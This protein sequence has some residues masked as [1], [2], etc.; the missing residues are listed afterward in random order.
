MGNF[1]DGLDAAVGS[2]GGG[3]WGFWFF[4]GN[5]SLRTDKH[6][7]TVDRPKALLTAPK[8][9]PALKDTIFADGP[10]DAS[11]YSGGNNYWLFRG[12]QALRTD[13]YTIN[14]EMKDITADSHWPAL[15]GTV[16][17]DGV[18]AAVESG[19]GGKDGFWFFKGDKTARTDKHGAVLDEGVGDITGPDLWP[20]LKDTIFAKGPIE[21]AL[22]SGGG[23]YWLF[24]G[25]Q[26]VKTNGNEIRGRISDIAAKPNW[27]ALSDQ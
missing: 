13:G 16:F 5:Q 18:D 2:E 9:W 7:A 26:T 12:N 24:K 14:K 10:I 21:A 15:K 11:V 1:R 4:K 19:S 23:W 25:N 3:Q 27:P 20:V 22:Y 6:G 17:A 8:N